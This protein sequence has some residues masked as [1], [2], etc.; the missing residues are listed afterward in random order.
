MGIDDVQREMDER[1]AV[2][3]DMISVEETAKLLGVSIR[4]VRRRQR[5]GQMPAQYRRAHRLN[6][7]RGDIQALP[8]MDRNKTGQ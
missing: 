7:L 5:A 6:Y 3:R 2:L 8:A 1:G 4:T